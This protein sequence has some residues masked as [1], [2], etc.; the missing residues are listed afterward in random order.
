M[1]LKGRD[2]A[3]ST[4]WSDLSGPNLTSN[5]PLETFA[6]VDPLLN[7][8]RTLLVNFKTLYEFKMD[9]AW[10]GLI[11]GAFI[12]HQLFNGQHKIAK[13]EVQSCIAEAL[14]QHKRNQCKILDIV[15]HM[16]NV[17]AE[18]ESKDMVI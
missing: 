4:P 1:D 18:E 11:V 16:I 9:N 6:A 10:S 7:G 14:E 12:F 17:M 2:H 15:G 3:C 5:R 8:F 13:A